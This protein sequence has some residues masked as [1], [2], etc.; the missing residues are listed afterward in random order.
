M[1][2]VLQP[3]SLS[4]FSEKGSHTNGESVDSVDGFLKSASQLDV[5]A[6]SI[7]QF[8]SSGMFHWVPSRPLTEV[9]MV[10]LDPL[11]QDSGEKRKADMTA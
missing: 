3:F 8:D 5:D 10:S 1:N 7:A 11:I 6:E 4:S 2:S 9:I